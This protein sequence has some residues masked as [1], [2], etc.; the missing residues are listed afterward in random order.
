MPVLFLIVLVVL[1]LLLL[2]LTTSPTSAAVCNT[3]LFVIKAVTTNLAHQCK[4][5]ECARL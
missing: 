3:A 5:G 4:S 1:L 2:L